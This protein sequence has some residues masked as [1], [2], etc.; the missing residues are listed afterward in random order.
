MTTETTEKAE[1]AAAYVNDLPD[2]SF[3]YI[4]P[5][6]SKDD[7]GK[8]APRSLR[9]LPYK[10]K[11]GTVDLPHLRN[12]LARVHQTG[13]SESLRNRIEGKL[14][15]I[16]SKHDVG[17][18]TEKT[19]PAGPADPNLKPIMKP[20]DENKE[21]DTAKAG[22]SVDWPVMPSPQFHQPTP[23]GDKAPNQKDASNPEVSPEEEKAALEAAYEKFLDKVHSAMKAAA[24]PGSK[25]QSLIFAKD[26]YETPKD[27]K[28]WANDHGFKS[29]KVETTGESYR[30]TQADP[31]AFDH[32]RTIKL[33]E[34]VSAVVGFPA[35]TLK[36]VQDAFFMTTSGRLAFK[37][38]ELV[39]AECE[40]VE[41]TEN[42]TIYRVACGGMEFY[43]AAQ[44]DV[45]VYLPTYKA[46]QKSRYVLITKSEDQRYTLGVCYPASRKGQ[47]KAD[48]HGDIMTEPELEK[49]AWGFMSK[50][51]DRIGLMHRPGTAG[52]GRVVESYIYRGPEWK[53]KDASG[54]DQVVSPGD[55]MLGVVWTPDAWQAIKNGQLTGYS[56]QGAA[57]KQ[58]AEW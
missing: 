52:A 50:G 36:A 28:Q 1:W 41:E 20:K 54:N 21:E 37:A 23:K 44:D 7:Q 17:E 13:L 39:K 12:A 45:A 47:V 3:A 24:G 19:A 9:H 14:Q 35:K 16:A 56:L 42:G 4:E 34:G 43:Y 5:G 25:V 55:W 27:A 8:T 15:G 53:M 11:D 58:F 10:D 26:K 57:R 33:T 38:T 22:G 18:S 49:S 6:G 40:P 32:M 29:A 46:L 48:F 30:I 31:G 2:S 51:A